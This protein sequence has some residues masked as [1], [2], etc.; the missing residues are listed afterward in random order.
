MKKLLIFPLLSIMFFSACNT[1]TTNP[2][3]SENGNVIVENPVSGDTVSSPLTITGQARVF[4]NQLNWQVID[5]NSIV[6]SEGT[7]YANSPDVGQFGDFSVSATFPTPA[8]DTGTVDVFVYSA[9]DGTKSEVAS[10]PINFLI[11]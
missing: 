2:T 1:T 7:A 6:I 3:I 9:K 11:P 4:E 10:V 8:T 5:G